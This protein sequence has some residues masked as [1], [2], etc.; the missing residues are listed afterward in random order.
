MCRYIAEK[1]ADQGT[2]LTPARGDL[3][4]Q[5]LFDQWASVETFNWETYAVQI[6]T[7]KLFNK[8]IAPFSPHP[9]LPLLTHASINIPKLPKNY[10]N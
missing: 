3:K 2:K 6:V 5:A 4:A 10:M 8:C 9:D 1:Y 7:Q